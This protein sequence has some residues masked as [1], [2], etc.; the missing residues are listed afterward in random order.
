M[1]VSSGVC[2]TEGKLGEA[3]AHV[4]VLFSMDADPEE[5][6]AAAGVGRKALKQKLD[7]SIQEMEQ[8]IESCG[9][10]LIQRFD[11]PG[12]LARA[13]DRIGA[14][15]PQE[16]AWIPDFYVPVDGK[17]AQARAQLRAWSISSMDDFLSAPEA[18][19]DEWVSKLGPDQRKFWHH[20]S[21]GPAP[22]EA[23][24]VVPR[25]EAPEKVAPLLAPSP[26]E[27]SEG[28]ISHRRADGQTL[29]HH[30]GLGPVP[31]EPADVAE[32]GSAGGREPDVAEEG[33]AAQAGP[34]EWD[35]VL[36]RGEIA[37]QPRAGLRR[38]SRCPQGSGGHFVLWARGVG[39][40]GSSWRRQRTCNR[41]LK[42]VELSPGR[43]T[44]QHAQA[45]VV[46]Q[47]ACQPS[48]IALLRF[49]SYRGSRSPSRHRALREELEFPHR[50][51][52]RGREVGQDDQTWWSTLRLTSIQ[53]ASQCGHRQDVVFFDRAEGSGQ[54]SSEAASRSR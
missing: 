39:I 2:G 49:A 46:P 17:A 3:V 29:W 27:A 30:R 36:S 13:C 20:R 25:V 24:D 38:A 16:I 41:L 9:D 10:G 4:A 53:P 23:G 50:G 54:E 1:Y 8:R 28:W 26:D 18:E 12:P 11:E 40:E 33:S 44:E 51:V 37:R 7:D 43:S 34:W 32:E 31:W 47:L 45:R 42:Q 35:W 14:I 15:L 5:V 19:P 21:L 48:A 52:L 22:W 6:L